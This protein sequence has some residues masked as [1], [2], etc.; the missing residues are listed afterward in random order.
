[1]SGP[2]GERKMVTETRFFSNGLRY[3][4]PFGAWV[5]ARTH[6]LTKAF[7]PEAIPSLLSTITGPKHC[8]LNFG[9]S[10]LY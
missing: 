10:A 2:S 7:D 9:V 6:S 3:Q 4:Q 8:D 5:V 1:M